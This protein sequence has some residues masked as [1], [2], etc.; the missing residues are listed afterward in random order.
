VRYLCSVFFEIPSR[1][2]LYNWGM[3]LRTYK[4]TCLLASTSLSW[5]WPRKNTPFLWLKKCRKLHSYGLQAKRC[6]EDKLVL[7]H[8]RNRRWLSC[9]ADLTALLPESEVTS[10]F[11]SLNTEHN[12]KYFNAFNSM[13][14][15]YE[16]HLENQITHTPHTLQ[17]NL[18]LH[19]SAVT[20]PSAGGITHQLIVDILTHWGRGF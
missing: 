9:V 16:L 4:L 13:Q 10:P 3:G 12:R 2:R 11:I 14:L 20:T 19:V 7:S 15:E 18:L 6:G 17:Y 8:V 1:A 5:T